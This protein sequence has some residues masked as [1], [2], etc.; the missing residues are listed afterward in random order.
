[1][2]ILHL[3][4]KDCCKHTVFVENNYRS[5]AVQEAI[6]HL[7]AEANK[8][9]GEIILC[10]EDNMP[11]K[12]VELEYSHDENPWLWMGMGLLLATLLFPWLLLY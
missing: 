7:K 9:K 10:T 3:I 6:K 4:V 1:M 12:Y 8:S 11:L 5:G 2:Y